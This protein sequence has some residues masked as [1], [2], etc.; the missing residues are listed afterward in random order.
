MRKYYC[1][2]CKKEI[3]GINGYINTEKKI[4]LG[5]YGFKTKG[6]SYEIC[7]NCFNEIH[8]FVKELECK[9]E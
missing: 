3:K 7:E 9:A 6:F 1:D 8:K 2:I 4:C 5:S